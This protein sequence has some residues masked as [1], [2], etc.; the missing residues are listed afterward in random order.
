MSVYG[1]RDYPGYT[2][3]ISLGKDTD[4]FES[5]ELQ[6]RYMQGSFPKEKK[7]FTQRIYRLNLKH[8][9]LFWF[10]HGKEYY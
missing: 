10:T 1:A 2:R 4:Q 7:T 5:L 3:N 8:F 6:L 9:F